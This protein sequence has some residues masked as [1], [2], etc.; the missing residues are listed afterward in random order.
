MTAGREESLLNKLTFCNYH[1]V[2]LQLPL[3]LASGEPPAAVGCDALTAWNHP[4]QRE[5]NGYSKTQKPP[6]TR[7]G[8]GHGNNLKSQRPYRRRL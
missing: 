3:R 2:I 1:S 4:H 8:F 6:L 7:G 5:P